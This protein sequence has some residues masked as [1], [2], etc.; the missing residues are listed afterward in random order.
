[1]LTWNY[2]KQTNTG[3]EP[4]S[5]CFAP[6]EMLFQFL[7]ILWSSSLSCTASCLP[8]SAL[9]K[10]AF[11][12]CPA[13]APSGKTLSAHGN[14]F[15]N[16]KDDHRRPGRGVNSGTHRGDEPT[17]TPHNSIRGRRGCF[18][19]CSPF[20]LSPVSALQTASGKFFFQPQGYLG[21]PEERNVLG[22]CAN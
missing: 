16:W 3:L 18:L 10:S 9:R 2:I 7:Q 8:T 1:M 12:C 17:P 21:N 4:V 20:A 6:S 15:W 11:T 19:S 22:G 14:T 5:V 13:G